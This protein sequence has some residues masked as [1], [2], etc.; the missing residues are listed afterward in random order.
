MNLWE[1]REIMSLSFIP[2]QTTEVAKT[3][4][5]GEIEELIQIVKH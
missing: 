5:L 3:S 1:N 4:E 2:K